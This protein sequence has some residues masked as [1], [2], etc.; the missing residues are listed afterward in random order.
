MNEMKDEIEMWRTCTGVVC[1]GRGGI[2]VSDKRITRCTLRV[3][4]S[5]S[6]GCTASSTLCVASWQQQQ[7]QQQCQMLDQNIN[8]KKKIRQHKSPPKT[9]LPPGEHNGLDTA[10]ACAYMSWIPNGMAIVY[11]NL[12]GFHRGRKISFSSN[13]VAMATTLCRGRIWLTS[14]R[15][16]RLT[17]GLGVG[18]FNDVSQIPPRPTLVA[19]APKFELKLAIT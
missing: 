13:F 18:L 16:L 19:V 15:S 1:V 10:V 17:G 8:I 7:Q 6:L 4:Q 11:Q 9:V 2:V 14:P 3:T 12:N 5:W